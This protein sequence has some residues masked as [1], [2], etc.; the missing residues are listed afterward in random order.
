MSDV[1]T[2]PRRLVDL[3]ARFYGAHGEKARGAVF[4]I[5]FDCPCL[6]PD[7]AWGGKIAIGFKNPLDGGEPLH[8]AGKDVK[9]ETLWQR[10]GDTIETLTLSPSI[11]C[12]GHWH[13]WLKNGVLTS[14]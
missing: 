3:N 12:V 14:C 6:Q 7:C 8:W 2:P 1:K 9:P 10:T 4:G 11:H 13:G 5:M